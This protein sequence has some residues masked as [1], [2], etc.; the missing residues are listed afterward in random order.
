ML[1]INFHSTKLNLFMRQY[2]STTVEAHAMLNHTHVV[3]RTTAEAA[4]VKSIR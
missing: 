3:N 2:H 4:G 1:N